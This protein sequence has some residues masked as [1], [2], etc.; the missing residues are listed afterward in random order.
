[1]PTPPS[2]ILTQDGSHSL[3]SETFGVSY[4]SKYGA[5]QES[6]HVFLE[7]GLGYV[8]P[9]KKAVRIF[10]M[11]FGTGLNAYL[12]WLISLSIRKSFYYEAVEAFPLTE[13]QIRTLNYPE[14]VGQDAA[15]F[16]QFHQAPWNKVAPI[17]TRF[18][19]CKWKSEIESAKLSG[20]FDVIYFDAFAPGSQPELWGEAVMGKMF[21]SLAP[22]GVLVTYCAKGSVKRTMRNIGFTVEGIPGPPGKREMTRAIKPN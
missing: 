19:L 11:G 18:E 20:Q 14:Q 12:T 6:R 3:Q 7:A 15:S 17:S 8:L 13:Q 5:I 9:Q 10:E 22:G 1:M 21:N 16:L 2:I 4:H